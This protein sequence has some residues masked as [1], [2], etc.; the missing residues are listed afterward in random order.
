MSLLLLQNF[1]NIVLVI[2]SI[3]DYCYA[4]M[5]Q[6]FV[7]NHDYWRVLFDL[8]YFKR[9][10]RSAELNIKNHNWSGLQVSYSLKKMANFLYTNYILRR[11]DLYVVQ[12]QKVS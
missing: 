3:I 11:I 1:Q 12:I 9:S 6:V 2:C 10:F 7:P 8:N 5:W 4:F